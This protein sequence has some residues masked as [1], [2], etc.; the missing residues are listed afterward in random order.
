MN[1]GYLAGM[2]TVR[3]RFG[4]L[5]LERWSTFRRSVRFIHCHS[6]NFELLMIIALCRIDLPLVSKL[7]VKHHVTC[8][9]IVR[10]FGG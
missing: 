4:V 1:F 2:G 3:T 10:A 7:S 6:S 8:H 5:Y 9:I